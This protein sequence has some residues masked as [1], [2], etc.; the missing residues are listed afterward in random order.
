LEVSLS[1]PLE[2][3]A[4]LAVFALVAIGSCIQSPVGF[5]LGLIAAPFLFLWFRA[6]GCFGP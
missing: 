3:A 2:P 5:G 1:F 6:I 4:A